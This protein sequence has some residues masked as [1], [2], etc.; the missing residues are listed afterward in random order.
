[1]SLLSMA[2]LMMAKLDLGNIG[3]LLGVRDGFSGGGSGCGC[4]GV[5]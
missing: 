4:G 5:G 2:S 3:V 1:M